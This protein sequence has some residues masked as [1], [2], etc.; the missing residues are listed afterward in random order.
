MLTAP[1]FMHQAALA[2]P[3]AIASTHCTKVAGSS[4]AAAAGPRHQQAEHPGREHR[5]QHV[6]RQLARRVDAG[7]GLLQQRDQGAGAGNGI[8]RRV[9]LPWVL[10]VHL[11]FPPARDA[12]KLPPGERRA[13]NCVRRRRVEWVRSRGASMTTQ[14]ELIGEIEQEARET[15]RWTG[16]AQFDPRVLAALRKVRREAFVPETL[17][18]QAYVNTPL[19]I[20]CGQTISQP[21]IVALMTDLLDLR[22]EDH[23]LEVGTGSGYQAAVLA[24]L[25]G[26]VC[27]IEVIPELAAHAAAALAAEGYGRIALAHRRRGVGLA[28]ARTVRRDHRHRRGAR[29]A[30]GVSGTIAAGRANGHPDWRSV[31]RSGAA[32]VAQGRG[33]ARH[34]ALGAGGR[35]RAADLTKN[36]SRGSGRGRWCEAPRVRAI[37]SARC[38]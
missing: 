4:S 31:W 1:W 24:E 14:Q 36:L 38:K 7:R 29:G 8:V 30:S 26:A 9:S 2:S 17:V 3:M 13:Q 20:G 33:W 37:G 23:V 11:L 34:F 28:G 10:H 5:I 16:R 25:S 12:P 19:P 22:R 27:S 18:G 6:R 15:A 21:Y 32:A 35:F